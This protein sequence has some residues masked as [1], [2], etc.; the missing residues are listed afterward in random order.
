MSL[1]P[2][3]SPES[4]ILNEDSSSSYSYRH[5]RG[6]P[7]TGGER[8]TCVPGHTDDRSTQDRETRGVRMCSIVYKY[9]CVSSNGSRWRTITPRLHYRYY[10]KLYKPKRQQ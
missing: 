7:F 9:E 4:D 5:R 8:N 1:S 6:A 2:I 3:S 10:G